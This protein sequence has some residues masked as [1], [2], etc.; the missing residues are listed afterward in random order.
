MATAQTSFDRAEEA[1]LTFLGTIFGWSAGDDGD[2]SRDDWID[3]TL[4]NKAV[5]GMSGGPEQNQNY[6]VLVPAQA[7]HS[8]GNF[9]A[10][11]E[12]RQDAIIALGKI[13]NGFPARRENG[14]PGITPH[15][16]NFEM[17]EHPEIT[18]VVVTEENGSQYRVFTL[19]ARFRVVYSNATE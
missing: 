10:Q 16:R 1:C 15:V 17:M 13:Q 5:F 4:V 8:Y 14:S 9:I 3:P 19:R 2:I 6:G 18:S 7:W 12:T 11:F